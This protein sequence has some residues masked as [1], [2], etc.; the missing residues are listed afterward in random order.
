[1]IGESLVNRAHRALLVSMRRTLRGYLRGGL[2]DEL[3]RL[4]LARIDVDGAP[5]DA[6]GAMR[7]SLPPHLQPFAD[8]R[9]DA[10]AWAPHAPPASPLVFERWTLTIAGADQ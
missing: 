5:W 7:R 1:M 4:A 3:D 6:D 9:A 10:R 8:R 2:S